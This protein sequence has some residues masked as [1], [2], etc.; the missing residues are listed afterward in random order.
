MNRLRT[1][2]IFNRS[3]RLN[4]IDGDRSQATGCLLQAFLLQASLLQISRANTDGISDDNRRALSM[5]PQA[6]KLN[7]NE[8]GKKLNWL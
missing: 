5:N 2:R 8:Y 3:R 1:Q 4:A 7:N 6:K